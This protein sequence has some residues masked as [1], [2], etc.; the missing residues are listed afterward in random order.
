MEAL[1]ELGLFFGKSLIILFILGSILLMIALVIA[2]SQHRQELEI[3]ALDEKLRNW[4]KFLKSHRLTKIERKEFQ[5]GDKELEKEWESLPNKKQLFVLDFKGDVKASQVHSLREEVNAILQAHSANDEVLVRIESPGGVV[6]TYGLASAQLA[7]LRAAGLKLTVSVD[8]VAA[9]G[10]YLMATVANHI[11]SSPFAILGSIG[12]V[13]QVPNFHRILKK[14]DVDYKE[15]T[16]GEYKRTVS[17]FGEITP[18]GEDKFK[19]QLEET[20][21]L[22]KNYVH[23]FRPQLEL[24]KVAT[25][26]YWFGKKALEL[27]LVDQIQTSDDFILEKAKEKYLI[28]KV[29]FSKTKPLQEKIAELISISLEKTLLSVWTKLEKQKFF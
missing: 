15:Y 29:K 14:N 7:R 19:S 21:E 16:A 11:I 4:G 2:K 17:I 18:Q 13:A 5:K 28:L 24:T 3:E 26:E 8:E 23:E 9:S 1:L 6:H 10:G 20:H 25:G 27:K 12:V 22:F